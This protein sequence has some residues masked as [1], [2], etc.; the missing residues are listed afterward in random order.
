MLLWYQQATEGQ[1]VLACYKIICIQIA[2]TLSA[3][4]K[5]QTMGCVKIGIELNKFILLKKDF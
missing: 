4:I 5:L 1:R 2:C 3:F